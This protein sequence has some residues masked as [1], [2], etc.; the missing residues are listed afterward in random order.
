[1]W[2]REVFSFLENVM[3]LNFFDNIFRTINVIIDFPTKLFDFAK[4]L[5]IYLQFKRLYNCE[6]FYIFYCN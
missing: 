6:I 3:V 1:M 4:E 5:F 2:R